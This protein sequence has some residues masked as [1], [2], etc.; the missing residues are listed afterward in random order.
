MKTAA[1][2]VSKVRYSSDT[3]YDRITWIVR[4]LENRTGDKPLPDPRERRPWEQDEISARSVCVVKQKVA[5]INNNYSHTT[6]C[7]ASLSRIALQGRCTKQDPECCGW[8]ALDDVNG[9]RDA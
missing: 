2:G 1:K 4:R 6:A 9:W 7:L 3:K 8:S 5:G